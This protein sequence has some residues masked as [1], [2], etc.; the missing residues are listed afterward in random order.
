MTYRINKRL[1]LLLITIFISIGV[2][3][4]TPDI[5]LVVMV[6]ISESM[7]PYFNDVINYMVQDILKNKL[8][9]GDTF[10]LL[11]FS[12]I[13]ETEIT[14]RIINEK[15]IEKILKRFVILQPLGQF[16]D[17]IRGMDYLYQ[18]VKELPGNKK[19]NII[20][21]TDGIHDPPPGS[22][23]YG[24]KNKDVLK[25]LQYIASEIKKEGWTF[26]LVQ[27]PL[28]EQQVKK[29]SKKSIL[30]KDSNQTENT[31]TETPLNSNK[32]KISTTKKKTASPTDKEEKSLLPKLSDY[33]SSPIITYTEENKKEL[34]SV[35]TGFPKVLWPHSLG[36]VG[37]SFNIPFII[38]NYSSNP[39]L[40]RLQEIHLKG[41]NI[42]TKPIF[43][44]IEAKGKITIK[45]QVRLPSTTMRGE[46]KIKL[47]LIFNNTERILPN[48]GE[49]AIN[50]QPSFGLHLLQLSP[51]T[52]I[53]ILIAIGGI[54]TVLLIIRLF[55]FLKSK[56]VASNFESIMHSSPLKQKYPLIEMRVSF[57]NPHIGFRNVHSITPDKPRTIGGGHSDFLIFLV[58]FPPR[59]AIIENRDNSYNIVPIRKE[60]FPN[61]GEK[62]TNC[63]NREIPIVSPKGHELTILFKEYISP[64]EEI[65]RLMRSVKIS[66]DDSKI[67]KSKKNASE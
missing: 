2:Y 22:P 19:K 26:H 12:S 6:D 25:K 9:Y 31:T 17:L 57:Q 38:E 14:A 61:S 59:I 48:T 45:A 13:P 58:Y 33:L 10:H 20:L 44:S 34:S 3:S 63:L 46:Q 43:K 64:L 39:I 54:L 62:I 50:Y 40:I 41:K 32:R 42:L 60:F 15:S 66:V 49:I 28:K 5:D 18:Y 27:M 30:G 56:V 24:L 29:Q 55:F 65:N 67:S 53:Y 37:R 1:L 23:Y 47:K 8:H 4:Q 52:L 16:T 21:I 51:Q 7:F 11:S 35:A 36:K